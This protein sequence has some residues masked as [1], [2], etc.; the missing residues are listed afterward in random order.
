MNKI[1]ESYVRSLVHQYLQ[2]QAIAAPAAPP[3]TL[4]D[5]QT[6]LVKG[7]ETGNLSQDANKK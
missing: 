6:P 5:L 2:E 4:G 1:L 7:F 3:N